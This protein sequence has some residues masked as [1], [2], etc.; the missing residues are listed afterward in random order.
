[1]SR[2]LLYSLVLLLML[3]GSLVSVARCAVV[4]CSFVL[5]VSSDDG[6]TNGQ[7]SGLLTYDTTS[8]SSTDPTVST[9][10]IE[11]TGFT[12]PTA[13]YTATQTGPLVASAVFF[14]TAAGSVEL[15]GRGGGTYDA[16][17]VTQNFQFIFGSGEGTLSN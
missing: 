8:P 10:H 15:N 2:S 5:T 9:G 13:Y 3:C 17:I 7:T 16:T 11:I 1:M 4:Q 6:H 12:Q 14:E